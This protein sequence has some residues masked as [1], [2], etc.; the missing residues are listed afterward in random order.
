MCTADPGTKNK[1]EDTRPRS[2]GKAYE[3]LVEDLFM[4]NSSEDEDGDGE[5]AEDGTE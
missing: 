4:G 2:T 3:E 1:Q 5:E